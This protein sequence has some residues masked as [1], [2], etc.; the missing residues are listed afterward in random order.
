MSIS[1][2]S[3]VG[4]GGDDGDPCSWRHFHRASY[5]RWVSAGVRKFAYGMLGGKAS[6][7][8]RLSV[9]GQLRKLS[10]S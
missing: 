1:M 7:N 2:P 6:E 4:R 3:Q 8:A 10:V 5:P 9:F